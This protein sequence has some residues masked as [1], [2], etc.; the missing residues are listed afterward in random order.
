MHVMQQ[1]QLQISE[2]FSVAVVITNQVRPL[3]WLLVRPITLCGG[4]CV[5]SDPLSRPFHK[6]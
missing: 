4:A 6:A 1:W 2:E 3:P 5:R